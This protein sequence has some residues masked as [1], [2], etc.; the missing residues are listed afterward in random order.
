MIRRFILWTA[1]LFVLLG[2]GLTGHRSAAQEDG[3]HLLMIVYDRELE[4]GGGR[5]LYTL[6]LQ[7]PLT[8]ET[9]PLSIEQFRRYLQ[10]GNIYYD[11]Q[12]YLYHWPGGGT[13]EGVYA[14]IVAGE[15]TWAIV[16]E[17]YA[18][19]SPDWNWVVYWMDYHVYAV[20][21]DEGI[22]CDLFA[23]H[24][25]T[26]YVE[27]F[28]VAFSPDDET[29]Y[30]SAKDAEGN[31]GLYR[32]RLDGND[33]PGVQPI[34]QTNLMPMMWLEG[35]DSFV[36]TRY[37]IAQGNLEVSIVGSDGSLKARFTKESF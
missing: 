10:R 33:E 32:L 36:A 6:Y 26:Q 14:D 16:Y 27:Y 18:L 22:P 2:S 4:S 31:D 30:V 35:T 24:G 37:E 13:Q 21:L 29:I 25:L 20:N 9:W 19:P 7:D 34:A 17:S 5:F 8:G 11:P 3:P 28:S 15:Y 1:I 23:A 12:L